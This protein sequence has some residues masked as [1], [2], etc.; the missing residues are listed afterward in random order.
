MLVPRVTEAA[1]RERRIAGEGA[2]ARH[3][4][5][6]AGKP[7]GEKAETNISASVMYL[8][9]LSRRYTAGTES[10]FHPRA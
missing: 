8:L 9:D 4:P 10:A 1:S 5:D 7:P 2:A 6:A 3:S